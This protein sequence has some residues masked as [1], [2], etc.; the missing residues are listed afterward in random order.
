MT[1]DDD[2]VNLWQQPTRDISMVL[3]HGHRDEIYHITHI[4]R[5]WSRYSPLTM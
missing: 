2:E 4:D 3:S 5:D 1:N